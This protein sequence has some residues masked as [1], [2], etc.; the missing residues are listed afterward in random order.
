MVAGWQV[1]GGQRGPAPVV[2]QSAALTS[3]WTRTPLPDAGATGAAVAVRCAQTACAV[4]GRVDGNLA[5]WRSTD[6]TWSRVAGVPALRVGDTDPLPAPLNPTGP[7]IQVV[8]DG[9]VVRIVR[10]DGATAAVHTADGPAGPATAVVE[11]SGSVYLVAGP[12]EHTRRL[13][14]ADAAALR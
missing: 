14:R 9:P 12:D 4:A 1:G 7:I 10:M 5:L 11:V 8:S 6:G 13:W 3:G 2:W